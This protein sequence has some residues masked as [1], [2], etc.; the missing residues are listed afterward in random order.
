M[1]IFEYKCGRCGR[2]SE[3][4]ETTGDKAVKR[5][6]HCGSE[7][8]KKQISAFAPRVKEGESK[9]CHGC[10]DFKCPHAGN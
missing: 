5:C 3:F 6:S 10:S 4:L 7:D 1:P 8:L 2:I 9:K